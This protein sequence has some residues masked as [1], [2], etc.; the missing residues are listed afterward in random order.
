MVDAGRVGGRARDV[1]GTQAVDVLGAEAGLRDARA[2]TRTDDER[3]RIRG[4]HY[5]GMA[6]SGEALRGFQDQRFP[7][8][9]QLS[10]YGNTLFGCCLEFGG[11]SDRALDYF[12]FGPRLILEVTDEAGRTLP[13]GRTGRVRFTRLD[14]SM[15]I[16][17]MR[18]RDEATTVV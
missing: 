12:L 14:E 8:A 10:G 18:E 9:V 16:I 13:P 7:N 4:V 2:E 6:L 17:R 11:A 5:G 3:E 1:M 15:L